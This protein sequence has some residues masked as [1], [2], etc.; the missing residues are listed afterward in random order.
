M[1]PF[2]SLLLSLSIFFVKAQN[3]PDDLLKQQLMND[4]ERAKAYTLEYLD[5]MPA[6]KY[7]FRALDSLR[8]FA[9]QMLHL[10]QANAGMAFFGTGSQDTRIQNMFLK[11]PSV[12]EKLPLIQNKDSVVYYVNTSYDFMINAIKSTDFAKLNEV[13]TQDLPGG[14]R[15]ASRLGWLL[16]AFEHQ[17]HHRGQ[18]TVYLRLSGIRP[19]AEKLW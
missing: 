16:K 8:S 18:C 14:K 7:S 5:A 2:F 12:F 10:A 13:V 15:S 9:Q 17:T 3:L 11:P 19:P 1:K 4:W 6:D